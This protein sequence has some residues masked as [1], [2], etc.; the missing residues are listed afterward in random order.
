M[1]RLNLRELTKT[2]GI[3]Y[4]GPN[5]IIR[6]VHNDINKIREHSL[7]FHLK[8]NVPIN[9]K[10]FRELK[11]AYLVTDQPPLLTEE[12]P[13]ERLLLVANVE[14]AYR[15]FIRYYRQLFNFPVVA[16]TGTCGKTS[17]KE[18]IAQVLRKKHPVVATFQS[19]NA[20]RHYH[21][22][23]MRFDERCAYGVFETALT[24][25]GHVSGG[26]ALVRP[27]IGIITKIGIDHLNHCNSLDLYIKAKAEMVTALGADGTLIINGDC[28]NTKKIDLSYF[29]GKI[30]IFGI[31]NPADFRGARLQYREKGMRFI[32]IHEGNEYRV[33]LPV[34]GR[35]NVYNALAALAALNELGVPL[36]EAIAGLRDYKPIRAHTEVF[37]GPKGSLMIDDTWSANPTS[38]SAAL[39]VLNQLG[40]NKKKIVVIGRISYLGNQTDLYYQKVAEEIAASGVDRL[41]TKGSS[42]ERIASYAIQASMKAENVIACPD[43]STVKARLMERLDDQTAVLFKISMLDK[44]FMFL[45]DEFRKVSQS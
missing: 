30:I 39:E 44:S 13:K 33:D 38:L 2:L 20:L 16:V 26:C 35:H 27:Q 14:Q 24:H 5:V 6:S 9:A 23:L 10:L 3:D 29:K 19:K 18:M 22:Y 34:F 8:K 1:K 31:D 11:D 28:E 32:L 4:S 43:N 42:A 21:R 36:E 12:L 17:T 41:I 25:P 15:K 7:T 45:I 40:A 37:N